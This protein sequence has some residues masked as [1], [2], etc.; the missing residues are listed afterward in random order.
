[1]K[2]KTGKVRGSR[3]KDKGEG[4]IKSGKSRIKIC[5]LPFFKWLKRSRFIVRIFSTTEKEGEH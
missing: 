1:V 5:H 4:R 3:R 2:D